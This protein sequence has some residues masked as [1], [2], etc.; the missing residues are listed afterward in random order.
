MSTNQSE[1][2]VAEKPSKKA[3]QPDKKSVQKKETSTRK[4][5]KQQQKKEKGQNKKPRRRIFPIWLRIVVV[6][7]LSAAA[8][9]SGLMIGYGVIGD[10]VP[11]DALKVETWQHLIDIVTKVE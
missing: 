6:V 11:T 5:Q 8:L 2:A 1:Q 4:Q 10:G 9:A 3:K 7:I